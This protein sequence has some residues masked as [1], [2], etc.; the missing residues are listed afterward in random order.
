MSSGGTGSSNHS[1]SHDSSRVAS[2]SAPRR[3]ELAVGAEAQVGPGPDGFTNGSGEGDRPLDAM[4][5]RLVPTHRGVRTRRVELHRGES[6]GDLLGGPCSCEV[7][8]EVHVGGVAGLGVQVGVGAQG[9]VDPTAEQAVDGLADGLAHD[10]PARH[11]ETARGRHQRD[12]RAL[13]EAAAVG[14]TPEP[15]DLERV[16]PDEANRS[17]RFA[18]PCGDH[19]RAERRGVRLAPAHD[20]VRR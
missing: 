12:V 4:Q 17:A 7:R 15:L 13:G 20:A 8:V 11:L 10:V 1:G 9:L 19:L 3:R 6:P 5:R 18:D 16:V 14:P 2:R